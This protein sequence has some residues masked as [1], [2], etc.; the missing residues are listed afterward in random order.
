MIAGDGHVLTPEQ[1]KKLGNWVRKRASLLVALVS[2]LAFM[3][4]V[5]LTDPH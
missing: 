4:I 1:A 5:Y 2:A 3:L